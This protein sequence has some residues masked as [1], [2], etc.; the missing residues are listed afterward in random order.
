MESCVSRFPLKDPRPLQTGGIAARNRPRP[1]SLC[2]GVEGE[3]NSPSADDPGCAT[4]PPECAKGLR[5]Q[6]MGCSMLDQL[7][8][9][10]A[11]SLAPGGIPSTAGGGLEDHRTPS[12]SASAAAP[13]ATAASAAAD[14]IALLERLLRTQEAALS[15]KD[16]ELRRLQEDNL[17]FERENREMHRFLADYNLQWVGPSSSASN[18]ADPSSAASSKLPSGR[19][20]PMPPAQPS[21][22]PPPNVAAS[23]A[24]ASSASAP[25]SV[26]SSTA[27]TTRPGPAIETT[28]AAP[29]DM[30]RVRR[31]VAELNAIAETCSNEVVKRRDGSHGFDIA[32]PTLTLT[33][34]KDGLQ[35]DGGSV[36]RDG[37]QN[38]HPH[39]PASLTHPQ[40]S[41]SMISLNYHPQ[42]SP[43]PLHT[44]SCTHAPA[45]ACIYAPAPVCTFTG[46]YAPMHLRLHLCT[47][48]LLAGTGILAARVRRLPPRSAGWL[49]PIR[50]QVSAIR[51]VRRVSG[52]SGGSGE[53]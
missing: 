38:P 36:G 49:F 52:V 37:T 26:K 50:A 8:E 31:A 5:R 20:T 51:R 25:A 11:S 9:A 19:A 6:E 44:L 10:L 15:K 12:L 21:R 7:D 4:R 47:C 27:S 39:P 18:R 34:W 46:T 45:L 28:P 29:P 40:L 16:H 24:S 1:S 22:S 3:D 32:P 41:A 2:S 43:H 42:L 33:F 53:W 23:A 17:R 35:L 13:A 14:R 30:E 48:V